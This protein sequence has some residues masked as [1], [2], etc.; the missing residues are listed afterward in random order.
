MGRRIKFGRQ[1]DA[2]K[3]ICPVCGYRLR[4]LGEEALVSKAGFEAKFLH[5]GARAEWGGEKLFGKWQCDNCP[6]LWL[7]EAK[8]LRF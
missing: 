7:D 5:T 4:Y 8:K 2:K 1:E 3:P 6:Q